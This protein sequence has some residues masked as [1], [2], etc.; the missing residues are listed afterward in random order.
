MGSSKT[1]RRSRRLTAALTAL[2]FL[3]AACAPAAPAAKP[4]EAPKPAAPA[5][6]APAKPADA[7]KP[8]E[9]AKPAADAKPAATTAPAAAPTAAAKPAEAAKPAGPAQSGPNSVTV[10]F[11]QDVA[12]INV[13]YTSQGNALSAAKLAQR[14][15]LFVD[16]Q[17]NWTP[18][19]AAEV[20]SLANGGVSPDGKTITFKLRRNVTWHDGQPVTSEDVKATWQA[21]MKP[22]HKVI[23]RYGYDQIEAIDTPDP[24]TAIIRFKQP[25]ASWA[26]LFDAVMP[27]HI[28]DATPNLDN[29]DFNKRPIGFGPF[30]VVEWV[31]GDRIVYEAFDGYWQGRPKI[32]RLFI[33]IYPSV[34]GLWQ[35]IRAKE[36]DIGWSM[37]TDLVP[38]IRAAE[39]QGIALHSITIA[40]PERYVMNAD[41]EKAPL[42]ADKALRQALQHAVDKQTI[43]ESLL[44][45]LGR[46]G[47]TEWDNSPWEHTGL[48]RYEFNPELAKQKL[49]AAGWRVGPDGIRAKDGRRLSFEHTTTSGNS[50]R[51]NVQLLVQQNFRDVGVE[52]SIAN[53]R[54]TVLFASF[55]QGGRWARGEYQMGGWSHGLRMPDPDVANRYLCRDIAS[56]QNPA[57]AQWYR[58]CN[59]EIDALMLQQAQEL[60]LERRKAILFRIQ[61]I[62]QDEAYWIYLYNAPLI[63]TAPATLQGFKLQAFGN[64]YWSAHQWEWRR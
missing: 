27:K 36:V 29:S 25:F 63:Y 10:G 17:S 44:F 60:D 34:E 32:D 23:S 16:E 22:D 50:Q 6:A 26:V 9:A 30:K 42:F 19:L 39:A 31:P 64:F 35:A 53:D 15:L 28:L 61:E 7:P 49:D 54:T 3:L 58:Y 5:T 21:V 37:P 20:P 56:E 33:R 51:E 52:M 13:F 24:A 2:A 38:E 18:E 8:T 57:G 14:G 46:V 41:R 12:A 4:T 62:L 48:P 43:V 1:F 55:G 45:G 47:N 11:W 40:N 59:P